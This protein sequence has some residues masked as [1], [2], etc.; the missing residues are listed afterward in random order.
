MTASRF[1]PALAAL[2]ALLA[3][4]F[5]AFGAHAISD[6]QAQEWIRTG[7]T[8]QLPHAVAVFALLAWRNQRPV[9]F[10]AWMLAVGSLLFAL[11]LYLLALGAP[12]GMAA[13]APIGGTLMMLGWAWIG[14]VALAVA[15]GKRNGF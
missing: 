10:G 15:K 9:Y 5:G 1:L 6:P 3:I 12:R 11:S 7:V 8:F 13:A 2:N 4:G 14:V